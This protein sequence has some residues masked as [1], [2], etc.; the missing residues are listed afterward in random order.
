MTDIAFEYSMQYAKCAKTPRRQEKK[1]LESA[2]LG[3]LASWRLHLVLFVALLSVGVSLAADV[4]TKYDVKAMGATG[5]RKTLDTP[6]INK[7]IEAA[8]AAGGGTVY[9][10]PGTYLCYSIHLKSNVALYLDK[11]ATI[12]AAENPMKDREEGYDSPE[13]NEQCDPY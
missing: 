2:C 11:G 6:A 9:F 7:A 4:P 3:V 13:P 1:Q 10:P 12:L 5:D 8:N